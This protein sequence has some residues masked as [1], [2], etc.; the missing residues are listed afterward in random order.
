LSD[1][2][3]ERAGEEAGRSAWGRG[4]CAEKKGKGY[5]EFHTNLLLLEN[6][7]R[8]KTL[9]AKFDRDGGTLGGSRAIQAL[10][11]RRGEL[12]VGGE[13]V[14][15]KSSSRPDFPFAYQGTSPR[16]FSYKSGVRKLR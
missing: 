8:K 4:Q 10:L 11:E 5:A 16:N 13:E 15:R 12:V 9:R 1:G 3:Y 6:L 7:M 2:A 14:T